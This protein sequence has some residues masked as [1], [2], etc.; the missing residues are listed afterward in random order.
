MSPLCFSPSIH[1][2]CANS[3]SHT[4]SV[5]MLQPQTASARVS[6]SSGVSQTS[7]V[8]CFFHLSE[9]WGSTFPLTVIHVN[10]ASG[11]GGFIPCVPGQAVET[12]CLMIALSLLWGAAEARGGERRMSLSCGPLHSLT[13][14]QDCWP[15]RLQLVRLLLTSAA[16]TPV[17]PMSW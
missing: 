13:R 3:C 2:I 11:P 1:E 14:R 9:Q 6:G 10:R 4:C 15:C 12:S 17:V 7:V 8:H 5:L 16:V